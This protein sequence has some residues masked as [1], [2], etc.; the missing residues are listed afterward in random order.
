L[1][2]EI[3]SYF[4][5]LSSLDI[6]TEKALQNAAVSEAAIRGGYQT[7]LKIPENVGWNTGNT[8]NQMLRS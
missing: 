6:Q 7:G 1:N 3:F 8:K 2:S 5:R 4:L